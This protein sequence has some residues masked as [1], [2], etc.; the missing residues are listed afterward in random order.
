MENVID[1]TL[2]D[3]DVPTHQNIKD[4]ACRAIQENKTRYSQNAGL[5]ELRDII[6]NRYFEKEGLV[7]NPD[8][9]IAVTVGAMEALYLTLLAIVNPGDEIII[10]A[11]YYV[12]YK[13]MVEMCGGTAV[14]VDPADKDSLLITDKEIE[15]AI[16]PNTK[17]ILLNSPANPSGRLM[18]EETI[19][20]IAALAKKHKLIVI[21]DEVYRKLIYDNRK[22]TNI[23]TLSGMNDY[24]V[25]I[26]SLSKE[27]CMTGYRVGYL[28]GPEDIVSTVVKLQ[29][30][31][32]AC[33]PLP[34]Q[35]AAIEALGS[36]EDYSANMVE[37]FT[38]RRNRL[39]DG[40]R[41]VEGIKIMKPEATF[42]AM[43]D[44][45]GLGYESSEAFAYDLL[46][47]ARVA[48]VP[49]VAYGNVCEGFVRIAF[50]IEEEKIAEGCRR[51]AEFAKKK[52]KN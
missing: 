29:E 34:S 38:S 47:E 41:N 39:Y 12:N 48:L 15:E 46:N 14:I 24:A 5:K 16:T 6:S 52:L 10:P 43:V 9:E 49:G 19:N 37:I 28:L 35:Y 18:T 30:N 2:G 17:A 22:Y 8:T 31:V 33:T 21:T 23:A 44:I 1:F 36:K 26:N 11:P 40:L 51:I 3:P 20:G 32:A 27:F 42:Y 7:Y 50:T 45:K 13:Q 4:A 25:I